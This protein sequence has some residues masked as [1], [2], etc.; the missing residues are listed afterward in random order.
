[1]FY[2]R[3]LM[4]TA[5]KYS[6][7][8]HIVLVACA[9]LFCGCIES[10]YYQKQHAVPQ[11]SWDYKYMPTFEFEVTDTTSLYNVYFLMRHTEAYPFANIW[12]NI[13]TK[14]PGD[15]AFSKQRVNVPLAATA[16]PNNGQWLGRGMGGIWEHK[17][18]ITHEGDTAI[19]RKKGKYTFKFEQNMRINPLPEVLQVG[20]RIEREKAS[21]FRE[22]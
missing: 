20:L 2:K 11:N 4:N 15:T 6:G 19:L 12:M 22:Q 3:V 5:G 10:P 13:Y 8:V 17:L 18:R 7:F 16:G 1:M 14:Q 21:T 9:A